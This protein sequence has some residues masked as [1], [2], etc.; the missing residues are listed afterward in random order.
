MST[1]QTIRR[2]RQLAAAQAHYDNIAP[3]ELPEDDDPAQLLIDAATACEEM[4]GRAERA[5][6]FGDLKAARDLLREAGE[7][8]AAAAQEV[9]L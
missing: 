5:A 1:P 7:S 6:I 3:P 8:L 9:E 4:I 2:A